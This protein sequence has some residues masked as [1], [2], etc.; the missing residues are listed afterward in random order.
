MKYEISQA[1]YRDFLNSSL[2]FSKIYPERTELTGGNFNTPG[3]PV[4]F[5]TKRN[6]LKATGVAANPTGNDADANGTF[7]QAS[8]GEW[9]ACNYL[10]W[11]DVAAYLDWAVLRPMTD[12]EFEN[13]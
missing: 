6:S 1:G 8:D 5:N 2:S 9:I 13:A 12:M 4:F 11:S 7:D 3:T 10:L